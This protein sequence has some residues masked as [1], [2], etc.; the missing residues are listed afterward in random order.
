MCQIKN[1][2]KGHFFFKDK[3][4]IYFG[5]FIN[6]SEKSDTLNYLLKKIKFKSRKDLDEKCLEVK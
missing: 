5:C 3:N 1:K 2:K 4:N 6:Q